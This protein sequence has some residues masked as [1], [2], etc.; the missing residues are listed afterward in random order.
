M[1][2]AYCKYVSLPQP[3]Q[4]PSNISQMAS[5]NRHRRRLPNPYFDHI[6]HSAM[7][8]LRNVLLLQLFLVPE[9]LR[10]LRRQL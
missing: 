9:M 3:Y 1:N 5:N 4:I 8:L 10:L 7:L 2:A 6:M